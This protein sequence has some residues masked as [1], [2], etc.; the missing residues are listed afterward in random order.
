MKEKLTS[1]Y[2][3]EIKDVEKYDAL[4]D[5]LDEEYPCMGYGSIIRTIADEERTHSKHLKSILEDMGVTL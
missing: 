3:E 5:E 2:K 1:A 4:A